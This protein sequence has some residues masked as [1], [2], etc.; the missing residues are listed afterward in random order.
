MAAKESLASRFKKAA[1]IETLRQCRMFAG[2]DDWALRDLSE[3]CAIRPLAKGQYVFHESEVSIGFYIVQTGAINVHRI[4]PEGKE[5]VINVFKPFDS[6]AEAALSAGD[7]YP[8]DAVAIQ[9][10]QV[11]LVR[12]DPFRFL[13][14]SKPDLALNMLSSMSVHL[15]HLVQLVED[16]KFK[17]IEAKLAH[18]LFCQCTD[19]RSSNPQVITLDT[20]KK[21]LASRLGVTS[22]TLSRTLAK[23]RQEKIITVTGKTITV[24]NIHGLQSYLEETADV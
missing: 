15:K 23:F 5:Q 4:S 7:V 18:W 2:L 12:K 8:V 10:S 6:F 9:P 3:L 21:V 16:L 20:T 24:I 17:H 11:V 14:K 13:L 1:I 19:S 22:E